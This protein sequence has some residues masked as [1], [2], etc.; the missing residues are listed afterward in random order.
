MLITFPYLNN[1]F[2]VKMPLEIFTT[3]ISTRVTVFGITHV[4]NTIEAW[5]L[6]RGEEEAL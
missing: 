4:M 3:L 1:Y 6:R 2:S 5:L